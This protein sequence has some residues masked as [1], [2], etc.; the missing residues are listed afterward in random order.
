MK[1]NLKYLAT[2]TGR[3]G[4]VYIARFLTYLQLYC[5]HESIF[6]CDG[7][8]EAKKRLS[9]DIQLETSTCSLFNEVK[10][11]DT[12]GW[13]NSK[14]L[15]AESSYMAAPFLGEE[16]LKDVL[17]IHVLRHPLK[18]LSSWVLDIKFFSEFIPAHL[19]VYKNFILSHSPEIDEEPTEIEKA[20][21]YIICWN[22]LIEN[23]HQNK[24][25]VRIENYP[26]L[27]LLKTLNVNNKDIFPNL[28]VNSWKK[29]NNFLTLRD[30]P[31]GKTK[32]EFLEMMYKYGY[33]T[34]L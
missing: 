14:K 25:L 29:T 5:G 16:I 8:E 33:T 13:F 32:L 15:L 10:N 12:S 30:I 7:I 24:V 22:R 2:G 11:E 31:S 28:L 3:C 1:L 17:V 4:T 20:C 19:I 9:G 34:Y 26:F 18:V 6:N 27:G 21:R 23:S